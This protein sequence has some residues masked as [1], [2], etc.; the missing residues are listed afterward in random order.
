[1]SDCNSEST[2]I[3][4]FIDYYL[5]PLACRHDSYIKDTYDFINRVR[6]VEIDPNCLPITADVESLYNNMK[7]DLILKSIKEIFHLYPDRTRPDKDILEVLEIKL[8]NNDFVF[9]GK[10]YLQTRGITISRCYA[11]SAANLISA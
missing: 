1:L 5:Q 9:D 3:C 8:R 11:P 2:R 6:D 4:E 10:Y 7:I